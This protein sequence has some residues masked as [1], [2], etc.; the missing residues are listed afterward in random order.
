MR[1]NA[2]QAGAA[3]APSEI[4]SAVPVLTPS[5]SQSH[6]FLEKNSRTNKCIQI[7]DD[8]SDVACEVAIDTYS[9]E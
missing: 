5:Y 4:E 3:I 8:R 2:E 1:T 7:L 9:L 6:L